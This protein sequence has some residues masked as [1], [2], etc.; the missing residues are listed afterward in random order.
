MATEGFGEAKPMGGVVGA[1]SQ[2]GTDPFATP[3]APP[4]PTSATQSAAPPAAPPTPKGPFDPPQPPAVYHPIPPREAGDGAVPPP[5]PAASGG[6]AHAKQHNWIGVVALILGLLGA[7]VFAIG[8][9]IFGIRAANMGRATNKGLSVAGMVLGFLSFLAWPFI[10]MGLGS[11]LSNYVDSTPVYHEETRQERF[12]EGQ[13]PMTLREGECFDEILDADGHLTGVTVVGC[14]GPH[15]YQVYH[16]GSVSEQAYVDEDH[17]SD[18]VFEL[19]FREEAWERY[20]FDAPGAEDVWSYWYYPERWWWA[21]GGRAY[22]CFVGL[23]GDPMTGS[24][25][26]A[27]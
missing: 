21:Q 23:D 3:A 5:P 13:D 25:Y 10:A 15:G 18:V 11:V 20:D 26:R 6:S 9:G 22:V 17:M 24:F 27:Q 8:A 7:G 16:A 4:T 1:S 12:S 14:A 2:P 19:C